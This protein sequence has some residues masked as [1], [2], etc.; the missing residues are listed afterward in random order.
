M[1]LKVLSL[2][3]LS[4]VRKLRIFGKESVIHVNYV[5]VLG[6]GGGGGRVRM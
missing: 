3:K 6:G 5:C 4:N 1:L 2:S